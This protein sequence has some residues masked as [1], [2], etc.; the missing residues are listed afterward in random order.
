MI[1]LQESNPLSSIIADPK[2]AGPT[3]TV[4]VV[5]GSGDILWRRGI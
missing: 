4:Q 5:K 2:E 3:A 1:D